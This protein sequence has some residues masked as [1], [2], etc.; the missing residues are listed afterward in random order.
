MNRGPN[1]FG[2]KKG[3]LI[4]VSFSVAR[5]VYEFTPMIGGS[6][7]HIIELSDKMEDVLDVQFVIAPDYRYVKS[8]NDNFRFD[9]IRVPI[10]TNGLVL[11]FPSGAPAQL[12]YALKVVTMIKDM[13]GPGRRFDVLHVHGP[14]LGSFIKLCSKVVGLNMPVVVMCHGGYGKNGRQKVLTSGRFS[15]CLLRILIKMF[16]GDAYLALDDG[17]GVEKMVEEV[18]NVNRSCTVVNHGID[19]QLFTPLS[20]NKAP[21]H[22]RYFKI[23]FPHRIFQFKRPDI[24]LDIIKKMIE[25]YH[26][27]NIKIL[28]L[29]NEKEGATIRA[30]ARERGII[31]HVVIEPTKQPAEMIQMYDSC[32]IVIGTST[33][34]NLNRA[35]LEAM[36]C[37]KTVVIF[38]SGDLK[39][40]INSTNG[41][42]VQNGDIDGFADA[43]WSIYHRPDLISKIGVEARKTIVEQRSWKKR[44]EM[45]MAVYKVVSTRENYTY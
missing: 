15:K 2:K 14:L 1:Y 23:L 38:D 7:S 26:P 11:R 35:I 43:I 17:T 8:Y 16:P 20:K 45:E 28:F 31:D 34:S 42:T 3:D 12:F 18:K 24:A 32:N 13:N 9:M 5:I 25:R 29:A 19:T 21:G 6:I 22:D 39:G 10:S 44:I 33:I 4:P 36:S 30:M 41:I 37:E 40:L 27:Y